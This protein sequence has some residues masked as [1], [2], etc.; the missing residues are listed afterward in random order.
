[1]DAR[2]EAAVKT[3][4]ANINLMTGITNS[5]DYNRCVEI[6]EQFRADSTPFDPEEIRQMLAKECEMQPE[7]AKMVREMAVKFLAGKR[8]KRR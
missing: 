1:M 8:V 4:V 6:F 3:L 7:D 2:V 5:F